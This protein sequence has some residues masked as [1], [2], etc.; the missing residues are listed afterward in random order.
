MKKATT[1]DLLKTV[2]AA[3]GG[4]MSD[5]TRLSK[6]KDSVGRIVQEFQNKVTGRTLEIVGISDGEH[7]VYDKTKSART[8]L[9]PV[10][11][12]DA[13]KIAAAD[14]AVA[15]VLRGKASLKTLEA[16]AR[17]C[18]AAF[19]NRYV[20]AYC[21]AK[22]AGGPGWVFSLRMDQNAPIPDHPTHNPIAPL[23]PKGMTQEAGASV[24]TLANDPL[25]LLER[26]RDLMARGFVWD[27]RFQHAVDYRSPLISAIDL[28]RAAEQTVPTKPQLLP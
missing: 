9:Y 2:L 24:W 19:A 3:Q 7:V 25:P 28:G 12:T 21:A 18:G 17:R 26:A 1:V 14:K 15:S 8:P 13:A 22:A 6:K 11:E 23:L 5:W 10:I 20:F 4:P 16:T 27:L